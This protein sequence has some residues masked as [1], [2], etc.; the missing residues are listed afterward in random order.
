MKNKII[1]LR[2]IDLFSLAKDVISSWWIIVMVAA[3]VM[4]THAYISTTYVPEYT[5]TGIYVVT[6]SKAQAMFIQIKFLHK[7]LWKIFQNL[8]NSDI[9]NNKNQRGL[10]CIIFRCNY[11]CFPN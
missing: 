2:N 9:M 5:S 3:G 11:E 8:M 6:P 1:N 4:F 10:A 7:M